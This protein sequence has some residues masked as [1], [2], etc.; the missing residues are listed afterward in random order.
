MWEVDF[1]Y[2]KLYQAIEAENK[3]YALYQLKKIKLTMEHGAERG[4]KRKKS[5][6]WFFENAIHAMQQAIESNNK[7]MDTFKT[8]TDKCI[9]CHSIEIVEYMPII[10]PW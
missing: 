1:R 9:T 2:N 7:P 5:Y 4:P 3:P 6:D 10:K 8:F